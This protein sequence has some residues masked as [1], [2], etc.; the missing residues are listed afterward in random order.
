MSLT[1][2]DVR[3]RSR[4]WGLLATTRQQDRRGLRQRAD[5]VLLG[6]MGHQISRTD[7]RLVARAYSNE[8]YRLS[9]GLK[10]LKGGKYSTHQGRP[11]VLN[12][13]MIAWI[14]FGDRQETSNE[15]PASS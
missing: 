14:A 4:Q 7:R 8:A 6:F 15:R 10:P 11:V 3:S 12:Q 9:Q 5:R 1:P 13:A 2:T